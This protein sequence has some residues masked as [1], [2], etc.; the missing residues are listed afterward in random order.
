M[1]ELPQVTLIGVDCIDVGRLL[2]AA[3]ICQRSIRFGDVRIL[4]SIPHD[5]P[6]IVPIAPL[7]SREAYSSFMVK[8]LNT[9]VDTPFALVIQYDGFIL[10][11]D[12]WRDDY[13]AYDY[14]GAP[15]REP[16]GYIVGNGGF[17]LRSKRLLERLQQDDA[18]PDPTDL[19]P[20]D[21]PED[22]YICVMVR[23]HLEER[24]IRWAPVE[25]ARQFSL[26]GGD[27]EDGVMWT[28]QFGF[29]SLDCTDISPWL[30]QHPD[31]PIDNTLDSE[32]AA[33]KAKFG[34]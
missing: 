13:L 1:R 15:W 28:N 21:A 8:R 11:P 3:A 32:T 4:T 23:D 24:G 22:W 7:T 34:T 27:H 31:E 6:S 29:H 12:A 18:I 2:H 14:I 25:L 5:H 26:E 17:S 20:P 16:E 33:L 10:N 9:Y 19:D 30:R